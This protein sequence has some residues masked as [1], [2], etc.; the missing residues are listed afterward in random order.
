MDDNSS[1]R[2]IV[3]DL[4]AQLRSLDPDL[5][6]PTE[7]PR[8]ARMLAD[9]VRA[10]R[11]AA[12]QSDAEA[13]A[14]VR[15]RGDWEAFAAPRIEALRRSLGV[16]PP[17]PERFL[18]WTTGRVDGDGFR[19]ENVAYETVPGCSSR[20]TSTYRRRPGSGC[21]RSCWSTA[22]TTR[23]PRASCRTWE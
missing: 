12:N 10:R 3:V 21:P 19:I 23:G 13:W 15:T 18:T 8:L 17:V 20:P 2:S 4:A 5:F 1:A 11:D 14:R 6:P 9:D 16:F 7:N 22:T